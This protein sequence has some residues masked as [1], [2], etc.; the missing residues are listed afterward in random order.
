[1]EAL[2]LILAIVVLLALLATFVISY[3]VYV[4]TPAPKGCENLKINDVNCA[5]CTHSECSFYKG[6][7]ESK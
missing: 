1:M 5:S 4:K 3:V 7:G 6:E 2:Y